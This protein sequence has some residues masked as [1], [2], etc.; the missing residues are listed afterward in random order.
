MKGKVNMILEP[1]YAKNIIVGVVY[2]NEFSWYVTDKELWF[3]D[4]YKYNKAFDALGI[5]LYDEVV[6]ERKG[7]TI[8]DSNNA[9]NF[10]NKIDQYLVTS[11]QLKHLLLEKRKVKDE[12]E[13][14]LDYS[15]SLFVDFDN[16]TLMSL[17][18]EPASFEAYVPND[19]EGKYED[20]TR[21]ISEKDIYWLDKFK[22]NLLKSDRM[23]NYE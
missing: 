16:R 15:P 4:Y 14:L 7:I 23:G 3:L 19:W 10:L 20:F 17:F 12:K 9:N 5:E 11:N 1:E 2:N 22:N 18:P 6:D 13:D 8:L 21:C